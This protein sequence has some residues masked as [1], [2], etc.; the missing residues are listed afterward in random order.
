[1]DRAA[2]YPA[3]KAI[4]E[5]K[6]HSKWMQQHP[7]HN[8]ADPYYLLDRWDQVLVF[9]LRTSNNHLNNHQY[10]K[11]C[12]GPWS[13]AFVVMAVRQQNTC[14]SPAPSRAT[15][16]ENLARPCPRGL[17][18]LHQSGGLTVHYFFHH[19][20]WSFHLM[21]EKKKAWNITKGYLPTEPELTIVCTKDEGKHLPICVS[22]MTTFR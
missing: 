14:C 5:A 16:K 20:N 9:W 19:S 15:W 1:M 21:H 13:R 8:S 6:Q 22:S 4:T 10:S 17:K 3:V 7:H 11:L 12:I 2:S 18:A